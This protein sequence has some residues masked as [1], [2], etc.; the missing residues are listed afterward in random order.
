M[1][2]NIQSEIWQNFH[3]EKGEENMVKYVKWIY[4]CTQPSD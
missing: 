1:T 2:E 4:I 3:P